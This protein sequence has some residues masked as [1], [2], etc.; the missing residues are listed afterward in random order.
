MKVLE[1][2][3]HFSHYKSMGIFPDIQGQLT[4]VPGWTLLNFKHTQ[5]YMADLVTCKNEDYP[6]K[7]EGTRVF[8]TLYNDFSG[9]Q[10]Q[11]TL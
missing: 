2:S 7:K 1:W 10:G 9:A 8:T 6:I 5:D 4:A 11:L 3:Q